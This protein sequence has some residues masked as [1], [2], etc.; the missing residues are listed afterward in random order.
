MSDNKTFS[1]TYETLTGGQETEEYTTYFVNCEDIDAINP[2]PLT[3][4][5]LDKL[6]I[7][8]YVWLEKTDGKRKT[9]QI[10]ETIID[11]EFYQDKYYIFD[12]Y[13]ING[14][15]ITDIDFPSR[16]SKCKIWLDK[17]PDENLIIKEFY[18]IESINE[19][20]EYVKS[21]YRS[22]KTGHIID[23]IILQGDRDAYKIKRPTLNTN[24]YLLKYIGNY[25]FNLYSSG[26]QFRHFRKKNEEKLDKKSLFVS[27]YS[28][29]SWIF[30]C[31]RDC[32]NNDKKEYFP[33]HIKEI[34]EMLKKI[35]KDSKQFDNKIVELSWSGSRYYPIKIREDKE[36]PNGYLTCIS[37]MGAMFA[38]LVANNTYFNK[39]INEKSPFSKELLD[40]F[41]DLNHILRE[42]IMN[43]IYSFVKS[44]MRERWTCLDLAGGRGGDL[45]YLVKNNVSTIFAAD[46]DAHAVAAYSNKV[47]SKIYSKNK[48]WYNAFQ[49][50]LNDSKN[51][52]EFIKNV[53]DRD[54]YPRNGFDL[55]LINY[56]IHYMMNNLLNIV[57]VVQETMSS[58]GYFAFTFF[59][60]NMIKERA[61]KNGNAKFGPFTININDSIVNMPLPTI[62]QSGYREEPIVLTEKLDEIFDDYMT[63]TEFKSLSNDIV[64][65]D[66]L[67][68]ELLDYL[69][70][71]TLRIYEQ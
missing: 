20:L 40:K 10:G 1:K 69:Q 5:I 15:I 30:D 27:P 43:K 46:Y 57:H 70:L 23:G 35:R 38:P 45:K 12:C 48:F 71:I 6:D 66:D 25:K 49:V 55:I 53:K 56:A 64:P 67:D 47:Y 32:S 14:E 33:E 62:D 21:N 28:N 59:D 36:W 52:E 8:K 3:Q 41:H 13:M 18:V 60:G 34:N 44:R 37:N 42:K 17:N 16:M 19:L 54:E 65:K 9:L 39:N 63:F 2:V 51:V 7:S 31:S 58:R 26:L 24:D 4:Q 68:K 61:D 11:T 29:N 50:N 22:P